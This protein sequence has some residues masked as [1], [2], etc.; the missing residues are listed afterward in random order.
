M[1][2]ET[3]ITKNIECICIPGQG[4][5]EQVG[6]I[7]GTANEL[8]SDRD[9]DMRI[10]DAWHEHGNMYYSVIDFPFYQRWMYKR[11]GYLKYVVE[12]EN[13]TELTLKHDWNL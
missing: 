2:N 5:L 9:N 1:F 7:S 12:W 4:P 6:T 10:L 13:A 11:I 8:C 3:E